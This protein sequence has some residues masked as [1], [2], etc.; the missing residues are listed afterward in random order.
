MKILEIVSYW[1][2]DTIYDTIFI[3]N[4]KN[5]YNYYK[6]KFYHFNNDYFYSISFYQL[7]NPLLS[8]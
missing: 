1:P 6:N 2:Y 5:Y 4:N 7:R 3:N 8:I